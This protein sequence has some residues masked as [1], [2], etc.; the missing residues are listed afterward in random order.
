MLQV[1][2]KLMEARAYDYTELCDLFFIRINL[3]QSGCVTDN[4][5]F[6]LHSFGMTEK[7]VNFGLLLVSNGSSHF[8]AIINRYNHSITM[9]E[10][11]CHFIEKIFKL[12]AA[13]RAIIA[14]KCQFSL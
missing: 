10:N 5:R 8:S 13:G 6:G 3:I 4:L 1:I 12:I 2:C 7:I 14:M 9:T 11:E